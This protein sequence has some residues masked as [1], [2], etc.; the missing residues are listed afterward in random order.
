MPASNS[1]LD[2]WAPNALDRAIVLALLVTLAVG[3]AGLIASVLTREQFG[4]SQSWAMVAVL[5][6]SAALASELHAWL[7]RRARGRHPTPRA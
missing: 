6:A 3:A 4:A 7:V 1:E 5:F 2:P